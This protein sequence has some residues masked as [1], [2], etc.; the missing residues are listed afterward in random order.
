MD[1]KERILEKLGNYTYYATRLKET[2]EKID[3]LTY[4]TTPTYG[5]QPP[6]MTNA[7]NSKV[8]NMGNTR[9]ELRKKELMY[10]RKVQEIV[11]MI[12]KSGLDKQEKELMWWM[13]KCG[14]LQA[15]RRIHRIG[16]Y[17]VYKMRDKAIEK[18]IAAHKLQNV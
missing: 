17:N 14:K 16:K 18:I 3:S 10:E 11:D 8:E 9:Y 6:A 1:N 13:A 12:E 5:L 4:K 7:F 2:R 15:F